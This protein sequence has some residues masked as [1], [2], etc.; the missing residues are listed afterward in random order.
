MQFLL[1]FRLTSIIEKIEE[2]YYGFICVY[3]QVMVIILAPR[4]FLMVE[5]GFVV[6]TYNTQIVTY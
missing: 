1:W 6:L 2:F 3:S 5:L 4:L